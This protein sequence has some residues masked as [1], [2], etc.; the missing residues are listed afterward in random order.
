MFK[1][2]LVTQERIS[3]RGYIE[4]RATLLTLVPLALLYGAGLAKAR[5]LRIVAGGLAFEMLDWLDKVLFYSYQ[6]K[7]GC[8]RG[9]HGQRIRIMREAAYLVGIRPGTGGGH[10][11]LVV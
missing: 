10:R 7:H 3:L 11:K 9:M 6:P 1:T 4:I 5:H 2:R 8:Y